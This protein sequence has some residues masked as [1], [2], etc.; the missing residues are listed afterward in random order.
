[1]PL[2]RLG[3]LLCLS[4]TFL[5]VARGQTAAPEPPV[6]ADPLELVTGDAQITASPEQRQQ[7]L[8]LLNQAHDLSNVQAQAY[9]LRATFTSSGSSQ[10][11][12]SWQTEDISPSRGIYRWTAQGRSYSVTN[13]YLDRLLYS[14]Q[15]AQGMP[16]RLAQFRLAVF[17]LYSEVGP[18]ASLRTASANMNG[19]ELTCIL[20]AH[21]A[22]TAAAA[23]GRRW[24]ESEYCLDP[25]SGVLVTYSPAPGM[26]VLYDYSNAL[27]LHDRIVPGKFT[28]TEAGQTVLEARMES[29]TD[30]AGLDRSLF[31][32]AAGMNQIGVGSLMTP[33]WHLSMT[34]QQGNVTGQLSAQRVILH[35]MLT[36]NG[37]LKEPE[38]LARTDPTLNQNVLDRVKDGPFFSEETEPGTTPQTHEVFIEVTLNG[39]GT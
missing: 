12:G 24:R 3:Y 18:R 33:P 16:L 28:I 37:H 2:R 35:G 27:H 23:H 5:P 14:N 9:H 11:D 17:F 10:Y 26:Y 34:I 7:T 21:G 39:P 30:P 6:P 22:R 38:V 20:I 25:K 13:L 19:T 31:T 29:L 15:P 8:Q 4:F 32:P 36:P 1:M